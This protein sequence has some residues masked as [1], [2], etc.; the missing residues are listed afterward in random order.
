MMNL[1][2]MLIN[3]K[4]DHT[5]LTDGLAENSFSVRNYGS[6]VLCSEALVKNKCK[7]T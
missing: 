2:L 3:G 5:I 6:I 7:Q 4:Y 1:K